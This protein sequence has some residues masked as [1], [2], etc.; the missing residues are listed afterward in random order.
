MALITC[1]E[2][3]NSVSDQARTCPNCGFPIKKL[4]HTS[5]YITNRG[6]EE[7]GRERLDQ[8]LRDGWRITNTVHEI[9]GPTSDGETWD[10]VEYFLE[11]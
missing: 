1:P 6:G 7:R 11:R 4:E 9:E 5:Q 2:C 3:K 8:L 10:V